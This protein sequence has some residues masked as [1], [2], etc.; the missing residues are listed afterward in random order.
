M[1]DAAAPPAPRLRVTTLVLAAA[2]V[3]VSGYLAYEHARSQSPICVIGGGGCATVANSRYAELAGIP[4]AAYGL[5]MYVL[6]GA[7]ALVRAVWAR[8]VGF[9]VVLAGVVFSGYLTV[10]ELFV[11][12]AICPWCVASALICVALAVIAG[13]WLGG[14]L[15]AAAT[16]PRERRTVSSAAGAR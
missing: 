4:V 5:A 16:P 1:A 9:A 8:A 7:L 6:V 11:I 14:A 10:L 15:A 3:A 13:A 12:D 2:G